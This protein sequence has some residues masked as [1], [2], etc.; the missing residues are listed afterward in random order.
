MA[1]ALLFAATRHL[2]P[3]DADVRAGE[4]FRDGTIPYQ[5]FRGGSSP[6]ARPGWSV[7]APS[8]GR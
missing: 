1:L 6:G 5:R 3:A 7:S 2:L 8:A 4:V